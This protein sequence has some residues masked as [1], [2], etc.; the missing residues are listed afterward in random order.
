VNNFVSIIIALLE[1]T[2]L[3]TS[4]EA[5]NLVKEIHSSTLPDNYESA[6]RLIEKA[7]S[8]H[9]VTKL[10]DKVKEDVVALSKKVDSK[11]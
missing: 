11:K 5:N 2:G 3:L 9:K 1:H 7:V 8:K 10:T 6:S 4:E